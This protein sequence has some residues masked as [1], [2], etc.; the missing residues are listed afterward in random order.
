LDYP[1]P[2]DACRGL[3]KSMLD[4]ETYQKIIQ[5]HERRHVPPWNTPLGG[6]I[7]IH[8]HGTGWN[9]TRGCVALDNTKA[10][11]ELI[12]IGTPVEIFP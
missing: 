3:D 10:L 4:Q 11:Y 8:G 12:P 6:E 2:E 9:W 7:F 5:A 1:R